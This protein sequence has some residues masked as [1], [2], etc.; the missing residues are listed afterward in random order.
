MAIQGAGFQMV[1]VTDLNALIE[2]V[3]ALHLTFTSPELRRV[4]PEF[5]AYMSYSMYQEYGTHNSDGTWRLWPRPHIEPA[6]QRNAAPIVRELTDAS[7]QIAS[8]MTFKLKR[9]AS[10]VKKPTPVTAKDIYERAWLR[11]LNGSVRIL[12]V[13]LATEQHVWEFGFHRRSIQGYIYARTADE[14]RAQQ[15]KAEAERSKM[16]SGKRK[17]S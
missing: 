12:A 1:D 11:I 16:A 14:I 17:R 3:R 5:G 6:V 8:G 2:G 4:N 10:G 9:G 13:R 15:V 7:L